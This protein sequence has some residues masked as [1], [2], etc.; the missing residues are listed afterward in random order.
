V[1]RALT[2]GSAACVLDAVAPAHGV[3]LAAARE[4]RG[5]DL[6]VDAPDLVP[7]RFALLHDGT[8][9][10]DRTAPAASGH[11]VVSFNC[12][13]AACAPGDYRVEAT[14]AGRPWIFTNPVAIE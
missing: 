7:A 5:L 1:I 2:D 10:A 9:I 11:A 13:A 3:R 14:F 8:R 12:P 4:G 6:H